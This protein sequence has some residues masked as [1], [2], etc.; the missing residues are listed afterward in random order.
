MVLELKF[1]AVAGSLINNFFDD[2]LKLINSNLA[3]SETNL[4]YWRKERRHIE[5]E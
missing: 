5:N 1:K 3:S 2:F 4:G